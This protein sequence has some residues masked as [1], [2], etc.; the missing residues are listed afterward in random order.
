MEEGCSQYFVSLL[1]HASYQF[2]VLLVKRSD[3]L[4]RQGSRVNVISRLKTKT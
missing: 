1:V 3:N 2:P 4:C